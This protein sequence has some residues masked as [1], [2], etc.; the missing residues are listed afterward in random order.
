MTTVPAPDRTASRLTDADRDAVRRRLADTTRGWSRIAGHYVT[1]A[2]AL[3]RT[4]C[5]A[6]GCTAHDLRPSELVEL[7][8]LVADHLAPLADP[9]TTTYAEP[10]TGYGT[11]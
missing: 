3:T 10:A 5:H 6:I 11:D 7:A 2:D 4:A 8:D 9:T 1:T